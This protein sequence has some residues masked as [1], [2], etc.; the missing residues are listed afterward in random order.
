MIIRTLIA[1]ASIALA[2]SA[3]AQTSPPAA[4]P[5]APARPAPAAAPSAAPPKPAPA[6]AAA[7]TTKVNL[8]TAT[9]AELDALPQIGEARSRA[10]IAARSKA[11]F[12]NWGDFV[13]RSVVPKNAESAIKDK[14][15]F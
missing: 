2:G 4:V 14:V 11:R 7:Q 5:P 13:A 10:I 3:L 8:N 12:K 1:A 9:A 15:V 6:A